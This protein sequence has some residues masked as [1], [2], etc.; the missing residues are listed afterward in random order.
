MLWLKGETLA[1]KTMPERDRERQRE[2]ARGRER[3][4]DSEQ[5]LFTVYEEERKG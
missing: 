5:T 2:R 3:R 4:K 1:G